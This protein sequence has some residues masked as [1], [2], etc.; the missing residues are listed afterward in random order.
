MKISHIFGFGLQ[1]GYYLHH[2]FISHMSSMFLCLHSNLLSQDEL[3]LISTSYAY[4]IRVDSVKQFYDFR[5]TA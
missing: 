3:C 2:N 1:L 5:D 4:C